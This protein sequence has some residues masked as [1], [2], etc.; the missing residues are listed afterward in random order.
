MLPDYHLSSFFVKRFDF[1]AVPVDQAGLSLWASQQEKLLHSW[2]CHPY[3]PNPTSRTR[4]SSFIVTIPFRDHTALRCQ[5][6][7]F[8]QLDYLP[9]LRM[10]PAGHRCLHRGQISKTQTS[11]FKSR[12]W[13]R[14]C[15]SWKTSD[16]FIY[17]CQR[18]AQ[19]LFKESWTFQKMSMSLHTWLAD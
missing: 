8:T 3:E 2:G 15:R 7:A 18:L 12:A 6:F 17:K 13:D 10:T 11:S 5:I 4:D 1:Q 16:K 9:Y 19:N 14:P